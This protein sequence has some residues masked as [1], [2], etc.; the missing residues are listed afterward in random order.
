M[1]SIVQVD[2]KIK[3]AVAFLL[4]M[5]YQLHEELLC[6]A[7]YLIVEPHLVF[8]LISP[9]DGHEVVDSVLNGSSKE[10][11]KEQGSDSLLS[12]NEKLIENPFALVFNI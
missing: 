9:A 2:G 12:V 3:G 7:A 8:I 1:W 11:Q 5:L 6:K 4:S 10:K